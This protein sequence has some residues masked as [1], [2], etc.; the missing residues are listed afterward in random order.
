[1][2][3]WK[4]ILLNAARM[5]QLWSLG[6]GDRTEPTALHIP[7]F[8]SNS[9]SH[10]TTTESVF[11][12]LLHL[13]FSVLVPLSIGGFNLHTIRPLVHRCY[14]PS[15]VFVSSNHSLRWLRDLEFLRYFCIFQALHSLSSKS[16]IRSNVHRDGVAIL[17]TGVLNASRDKTVPGRV[18]GSIFTLPKTIFL[19]KA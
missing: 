1:M 9:C 5:N 8:G 4:L 12:G 11:L 18:K 10:C 17:Y 7:P 2:G 13:V 3:D 19:R 15:A 16:G 6:C 14:I